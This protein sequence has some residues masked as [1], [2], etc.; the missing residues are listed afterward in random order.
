MENKQS[1]ED[2]RNAISRMVNNIGSEALLL[3][4]YRFIQYIYIYVKD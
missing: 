4:I 2:L 3:R 1:S